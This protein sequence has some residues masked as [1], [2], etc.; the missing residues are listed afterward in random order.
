MYV[1]T[2]RAECL[3]YSQWKHPNSKAKKTK[4]YKPSSIQLTCRC[5][6]WRPGLS[7][8]RGQRKPQRR[9]PEEHTG[10]LRR[11]ASWGR[12]SRSGTTAAAA[13]TPLLIWLPIWPLIWFSLDLWPQSPLTS[14]LLSDQ[15]SGPLSFCH[16]RRPLLTTEALTV[17]YSFHPV[18]PPISR[19]FWVWSALSL[20]CH[21][22]VAC[23][24]P[25]LPTCQPPVPLPVS[26]PVLC[27]HGVHP[28]LHTA[29]LT[30]A[31]VTPC[32]LAAGAG[33]G[34]VTHSCR[35]SYALGAGT[36]RD[37]I[38]WKIC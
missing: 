19:P 13:T 35:W 10:T 17:L 14:E 12:S 37:R 3:H 2:N 30:P 11:T 4:Y 20:S 31:Q 38:W 1:L 29:V 9:P 33:Q 18:R 8:I 16:T 25:C 34:H 36:Y 26:V 22:G 23:L 21:I 6:S 7:A 32:E 28:T 5:R 15:T 24:C 27:S